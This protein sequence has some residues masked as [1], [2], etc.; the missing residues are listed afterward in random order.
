MSFALNEIWMFLP[1][2]FPTKKSL[3][4][5]ITCYHHLCWIFCRVENWN[6]ISQKQFQPSFQVFLGM[7]KVGMNSD[8][9]SFDKTWL[10]CKNSMETFQ[11]E[12]FP[13][14][15]EAKATPCLDRVPIPRNGVLG[16]M[17]W[18]WE[19]V[20]GCPG[21]S[22]WPPW[23]RLTVWRFPERGQRFCPSWFCIC[24]F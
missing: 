24:C 4:S 19:D 13:P 8:P 12:V 22:C 17:T 16:A 15:P 2:V 21:S 20:I 23:N 1:P 10:S 3:C 7:K 14:P 5:R 9:S 6:L 11:G 18:G